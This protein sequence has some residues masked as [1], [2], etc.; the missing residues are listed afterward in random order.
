MGRNAVT[1]PGALHVCSAAE[2]D[3]AAAGEEEGG[4]QA[5]Q[6][7]VV[8]RED[9]FVRVVGGGVFGADGVVVRV[10]CGR[11]HVAGET[12]EGVERLSL[13]GR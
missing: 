3:V 7:G 6:V 9:G 1:C 10:G 5:V 8:G 2:Q 4:R 12:F 11:V 13:R